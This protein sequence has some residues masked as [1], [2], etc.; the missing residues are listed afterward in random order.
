MFVRPNLSSRHSSRAVASPTA[1]INAVASKPALAVELGHYQRTAGFW[2]KSDSSQKL[3][4]LS[5]SANG[6][7]NEDEPDCVR[8]RHHRGMSLSG[9]ILPSIRLAVAALANGIATALASM[10]RR[11]THTPNRQDSQRIVELVGF[12]ARWHCH[13][14]CRTW[15]AATVGARADSGDA[16][17][18]RNSGQV[19]SA[20]EGNPGFRPGAETNSGYIGYS[21]WR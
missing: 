3:N 1:R 15:Q 12:A 19:A 16:C 2:L 18:R 20:R 7:R 6:R 17:S 4:N 9:D 8:W 11:Q 10:A 5:S 21:G 14:A 13:L